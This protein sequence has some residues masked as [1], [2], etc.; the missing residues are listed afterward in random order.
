MQDGL[1]MRIFDLFRAI[2]RWIGVPLCVIFS[3]FAPLK[4]LWLRIFHKN[5]SSPRKILVIKLVEIGA[6]VHAYPFFNKI[7][8]EFSSAEIYILTF[9]KNKEI[10]ELF[11]DT[12]KIKQIIAISE[13]GFIPMVIDLIRALWLLVC[14]K[15]DVAVDLEFFARASALL[16]FFSGASKTVGFYAYGFEGLYRG[17]FLTHKVSY[18]PLAHIAVNYLSLAST[19]KTSFKNS[20]EADQFIDKSSLIFPEYYSVENVRKSLVP[21]RIPQNKRLFLMNIGEGNIP[22]REWPLINFKI[23]AESILKDEKNVLLLVGTKDACPK[24]EELIIQF[25]HE[26]MINYCGRS[27]LKQLMEIFLISHALIANDGG[28]GHLAMLTPIKKYILYGPETP[29]VFSPL[30]PNTYVFY[31]HWPC[32]PCLSALNHRNSLCR[33]NKCLKAIVPQQVINALN[34]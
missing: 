31:S 9:A 26:R 5:N 30:G 16:S 34:L 3:I 7:Q 20:P 32:S 18:N 13:E 2:D 8:Q 6:V 14:I 17:N 15:V 27:N 22:L 12:I 28:L 1:K 4:R 10:F 29:Q 23:V 24:A 25:K 33:D 19:L 11:Q 21:L